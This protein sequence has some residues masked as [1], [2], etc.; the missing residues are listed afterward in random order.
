MIIK[1]LRIMAKF[2]EDGLISFGNKI[3]EIFFFFFTKVHFIAIL[4]QISNNARS[5]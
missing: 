2:C 5:C 3:I 1:I 4:W